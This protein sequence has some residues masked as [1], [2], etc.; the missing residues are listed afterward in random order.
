MPWWCIFW[1]GLNVFFV[2]SIF[3]N[4]LT[5]QLSQV[6]GVFSEKR[7]IIFFLC[8]QFLGTLQDTLPRGK[9]S[10]RK[11]MWTEYKTKRREC[12]TGLSKCELDRV[13]CIVEKKNLVHWPRSHLFTKWVGEGG[14]QRTNKFSNYMGLVYLQISGSSLSFTPSMWASIKNGELS[15]GTKGKLAIVTME[16]LDETMPYVRS[17]YKNKTEKVFCYPS[18]EESICIKIS[19]L[20]QLKNETTL[21]FSDFFL[22]HTLILDSQHQQM[23]FNPLGFHC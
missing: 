16:M 19:H 12:L 11:W 1:K 18:D 4:S 15:T 17:C 6:K 3:R 23:I 13:G 2:L 9:T 14:A 21:W 5:W 8:C 20:F 7:L 10:L 22:S